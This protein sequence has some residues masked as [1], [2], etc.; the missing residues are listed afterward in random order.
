MVTA[1]DATEDLVR[2]LDIGADDYLTK[3]F[4]FEELRQGRTNAGSRLDLT[5]AAT[6]WSMSE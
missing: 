4:S 5:A 1:R 2:G 3:P 6:D